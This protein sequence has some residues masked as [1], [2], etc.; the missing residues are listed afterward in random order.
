MLAAGEVHVAGMHLFDAETSEFNVPEVRQRLPCRA[1][2]VV[3]LLHWEVGVAV[4]AGNPKRIRAV[5][6]L[7]R[8]GVT[9]AAR[10]TGAAVHR[11]VELLLQQAGLSARSL[12]TCGPV[13]ENHL[14]A[15]RMVSMGIADAAVTLQSSAE[16]FALDFVPLAR[17]RF[18]LVF[19]SA[20]ETEPRMVRLL[21]A[22]ASSGFR[23]DAE[24]LGGLSARSA[25]SVIARTA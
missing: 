5:E 19:P 2:S 1:M 9:V 20:M 11:R 3:S 22:L 6:G 18:D 16:A 21:E 24:A 14:E 15:A 8:P 10:P 12:K 4:R 13:A 23:R 25:G 17:E 7:V